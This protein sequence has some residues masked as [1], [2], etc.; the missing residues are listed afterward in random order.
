MHRRWLRAV[1]EIGVSLAAAALLAL[2]CTTIRV[3]PLQ[4]IGQISGLA[5]IQIRFLMIA[6]P[7]VL[8][9]VVTAR[10]RGGKHFALTARIVCAALAGL[11]SGYVASGIIVALRGTPYCLNANAG[12]SDIIVMWA[13]ALKTGQTGLY[14]P[15]FYPPLFPH[16]LRYYMEATD[17][18]AVY[19]LK[20]LQI[21]CTALVGP[22]AYLSWR[23]VLRPGWALGIGVMAALVVIDPYK[24]YGN[25]VLVVF[26]PIAI[27]YLARLREAADRAPFELVRTGVLYGLAFG[28]LILTY[29]GWFRWAVPGLVGAGL[30]VFPWRRGWKQGLLL[31]AVTLVVIVVVDWNYF[32]NTYEYAAAIS[33]SSG[34]KTPMIVDDYFYFDTAIDPT[35]FAMWKGDMPGSTAIRDFPPTGELGGIGLYSLVLFAGLG[36]AVALGRARTELITVLGVLIAT[37]LQRFWVAHN[38]YETKLV[39]L[40]PRTTLLLAYGF[41]VVAGLAVYYVYERALK[42][43]DADSAWRSPNAHIGAIVALVMLFGS[44][45]SATADRYMPYDS[46]PRTLGW[47]SFAAHDAKKQAK[48]ALETPAPAPQPPALPPAQP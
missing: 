10:L 24:P 39:Q 35:Y 28:L 15:A 43:A 48:K 20:D 13:N 37:W 33:K 3:D 42:R 8:A 34:G 30:V 23:L 9:L 40:W 29:S 45:A 2:A 19:A 17:Q 18:S 25:L 44:I 47:L 26:V 6:I 22:A 36:I 7:L 31:G 16:A 41:V 4:R 1:I 27:R 14:P 38:M 11:A 46:L 21:I 32:T 5:T 12:D